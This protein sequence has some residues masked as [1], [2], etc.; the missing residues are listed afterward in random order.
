MEP[1]IPLPLP[2]ASPTKPDPEA[3]CAET[4]ESIFAPGFT[5]SSF[6]EPSGLPWVFSGSQGLRAGW[7]VLL[8]VLLFAFS[9]PRLDFYFPISI[10]ASKRKTLPP[11]EPSSQS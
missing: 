8:F 11:R 6:A 3:L 1:E 5:E 9:A 7:S 10:S 4:A 2:E